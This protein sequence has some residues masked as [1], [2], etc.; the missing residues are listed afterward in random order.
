MSKDSKNL[1]VL[2]A[3]LGNSI[4]GFSFMFSKV[5]LNEM[6]PLVLLSLRFVIAFITLNCILLIFK[7]KIR[8]KGKDFYWL[9]LLGILQPILYFLF[10]NYGIENSTASFSGIMISLIPIVALSLGCII[11]KEK[12][13]R[14]QIMF[15][16]CSIVGVIIL[17]LGKQE[18]QTGVKGFLLLLGAVFSGA[19]FNILS[20]KTSSSYSAFE[21]TYFMFLV[22]SIFFTVAAILQMKGNYFP[23]FVKA[24]QSEKILF[25]IL[26][27]A[28][29]SSVGAML[30]LNFAATHMPVA[31]YSSFANLVTVVAIFAGIIF[32]KE[33]FTTVQML[34]SVLIILGV[35]G[36]NRYGQ[37][38]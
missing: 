34:G 11:L 31:K 17:S 30:L 28:V 35:F 6:S 15:S 1:A 25:S 8:F 24:F 23:L 18:G 38:T 32:L 22:G 21:R 33:G 20:R 16:A 36:V 29:I 13:T 10:E 3:F 12:A 14:L 4:F 5:A 27:L 19:G 2:A 7:I 37:N 9:L 26:Y